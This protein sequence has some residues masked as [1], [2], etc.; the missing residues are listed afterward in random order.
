V[1][2]TAALIPTLSFTISITVVACG[3]LISTNVDP[4]D[5]A[6]VVNMLF[7]FGSI[8]C[9]F[10]YYFPIAWQVL[11]ISELLAQKRKGEEEE[12]D[13]A[14]KQGGEVTKGGAFGGG[15]GGG[16]AAGEGGGAV[17]MMRRITHATITA[18]PMPAIGALAG[19]G[20]KYQKP[21]E[22]WLRKGQSQKDAHD[23]FAVWLL[24][25]QR[26]G[27]E[28]AALC[29]E[30]ILFWRSMLMLLA[31]GDDNGIGS[32]SES[33]VSTYEGDEEEGTSETTT[34]PTAELVT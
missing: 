15:V 33:R 30:K 27:D 34:I 24:Q 25:T 31:E 1:N 12:S 20:E 4:I 14:L 22:R 5:Y 21:E 16:G 18:K 17:A 23:E 3:V 19:A 9:N 8:A 7:A 29:Q 32:N 13:H 11:G 2:E 6:F 10:L 28:K 26:H